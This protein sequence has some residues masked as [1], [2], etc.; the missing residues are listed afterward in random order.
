MAKDLTKAMI[1]ED[2][3]TDVELIKRQVKKVWPDVVFAIARNKKE[4][5]EKLSWFVPDIILADYR[6]PDSNGLEALLY[7]KQ[8]HANVPFVFVT[9]TLNNEEKV[10]DAVLHGASGYILKENLNALSS[11]LEEVWEDYLIHLNA[12]EERQKQTMQNQL[13]LQKALALLDQAEDFGVKQEVR[14]LISAVATQI[15]KEVE[16][17]AVAS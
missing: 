1:L 14:S 6:L 10:A 4:F 13:L 11:K 16:N 3:P 2:L 12:V 17:R 15:G 8:Y 7:V 5:L 9:G